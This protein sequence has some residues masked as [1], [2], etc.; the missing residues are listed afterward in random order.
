MV[1]KKLARRLALS[2]T[3][4]AG[5]L[6]PAQALAADLDLSGKTVEWVIPFSETGGSA[7][8]ANF[9]APLLS[10]ALPGQ[11]TVV[12][13][14][15][16]GAGST[17]GANWFQNQKFAD[18]EGTVIFGSSGSTQFPYLLGD[19][20]V[21]YDYKDW[22]VVLASGTGGV[23]Y[24]PPDLASKMNGNDASALKETDFIYGSQGAT[25]LD[26]VPLLAWEMLGLNVEPVFGIK[27]RG[28]GRLMFERGEANIDYQTSSSYLKG[29]TPLVEAGTA[30]P[31]MSW[32][33]LDADGNI[34]RDPT[35]PDMPT[36]KEVC[37]AT[38]GCETSGEKWDAWKAFFI[39][40]FPAQK[41][42]FLP[43][44]A[45]QDA[46]DTYSKAFDAVKARGDFAEISAGRLG[47]YPQ[48]TGA[49]ADSAL[50]SAT[51]VPDSAKEFVVG[52]LQER[53]G[54]SLK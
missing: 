53:Y 28:D 2:V 1:L 32:G 6:V 30:V 42:V 12:V 18:S 49:E 52:W 41:M 16:P 34:V 8:W 35:F 54:V 27:G 19:P 5:A 14:F 9:Y 40:G 23:A 24:L 21:R 51:E 45:S 25:R 46:I 43:N 37:E 39:A 44:G 4:A 33:A 38:E 48:M 7:K 22:N 47:K 29:V 17:K 20:R 11:P 3:L 26:L 15:M 50:K 13:K 36:F 10:E 31:M